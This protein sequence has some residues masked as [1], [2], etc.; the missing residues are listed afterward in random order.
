MIVVDTLKDVELPCFRIRRVGAKD[1]ESTDMGGGCYR[2]HV[3][4]VR[5]RKL[6]VSC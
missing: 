3:L 4:D 6:S 2:N 1:G 5:G